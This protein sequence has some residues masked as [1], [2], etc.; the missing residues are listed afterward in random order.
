M[1][2]KKP[3]SSLEALIEE[4]LRKVYKEKEAEVI[5]ARLLEL[6]RQLK[7]QESGNGAT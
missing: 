3:N 7:E 5:P 4:N 2:Q 1:K 6:L